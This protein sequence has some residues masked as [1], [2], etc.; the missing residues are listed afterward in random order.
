MIRLRERFVRVRYINFHRQRTHRT[1]MHA[2]TSVHH[3]NIY[4][5]DCVRRPGGDACSSCVCRLIF[6]SLAARRANG[7]LHLTYLYICVCV[8]VHALRPSAKA[9]LQK[10]TQ[11]ADNIFP[12]F[13]KRATYKRISHVF[14][15]CACLSAHTCA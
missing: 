4:L 5:Y 2:H 3:I 9:T 12:P 8:C 13:I 6:L 14:T 10:N 1:H 15:S 11:N 7:V